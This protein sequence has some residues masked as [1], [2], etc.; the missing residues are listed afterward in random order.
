M[1]EVPDCPYCGVAV[2]TDRAMDYDNKIKLRCNNCGGLFEFM[3]GFGAFSLPENERRGSVRHEGSR[4][5]TSFDIYE[6]EAPW[7][8]A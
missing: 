2:Q 3:P 7:E 6:E 1:S 5:R 4:R 8:T